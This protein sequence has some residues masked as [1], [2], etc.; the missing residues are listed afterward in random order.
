MSSNLLGYVFMKRLLFQFIILMSK[1]LSIH[2]TSQKLL[3]KK[4]SDIYLS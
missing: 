4:D 1:R 2:Y 3:A